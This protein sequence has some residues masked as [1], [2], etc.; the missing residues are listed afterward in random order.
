MRLVFSSFPRVRS[1]PSRGSPAASRFRLPL[2]TLA[3]PASE[4]AAGLGVR[5]TG[6]PR[7]QS[8]PRSGCQYPRGFGFKTQPSVGG[9]A[10]E[11]GLPSIPSPAPAPATPSPGVRNIGVA[12]GRPRRGEDNTDSELSS[13]AD[14]SRGPPK[15]QYPPSPPSG[16]PA[17]HTPE[18]GPGER[19][20]ALGQSPGHV[21]GVHG[22][23]VGG[24]GEGHPA[25]GV[26]LGPIPA[27]VPTP[28]PRP[29]SDRDQWP[30]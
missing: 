9:G 25:G 21:A 29:H 3:P 18:S 19:G 12:P 10:L 23:S 7:P 17:R 27:R 16:P 8:G 30:S 2:P 4:R 11:S 26:R 24:P 22:G 14:P 13:R 6:Q 1:T 28:K 20:T 15:C 5:L